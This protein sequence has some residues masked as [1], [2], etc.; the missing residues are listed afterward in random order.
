MKQAAKGESQISFCEFPGCAADEAA[1]D[2]AYRKCNP[3]SNGRLSRK[4]SIF[5]FSL[6]AGNTTTR[7]EKQARAM[8]PLHFAKIF[9]ALISGTAAI[10][11]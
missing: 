4:Q 6:S 7:L 9:G 5:L 2:L 3:A 11:G 10:V 1:G 8:G